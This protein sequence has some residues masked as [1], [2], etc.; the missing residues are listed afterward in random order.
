MTTKDGLVALDGATPEV[1]TDR[2]VQ[3][4]KVLDEAVRLRDVVS[5]AYLELGKVLYRIN[6]EGLYLQ[7]FQRYQTFN[8]YVEQELDFKISK[9][10]QL[11]STYWWFAEKVG[12]PELLAGL[13]EIGWTKAAML[14]G[15]ADKKSG[16]EWI[17]K[18]KVVSQDTLNTITKEALT[19]LGKTRRPRIDDVKPSGVDFTSSDGTA[20]SE[21][22]RSDNPF[23]E[24]AATGVQARAPEPEDGSPSTAPEEPVGAPPPTD[25]QVAEAEKF[26]V[27]SVPLARD[28]QSRNVEHA[29]EVAGKMA[30]SNKKSHLLDLIATHFLAASGA[31]AGDNWPQHRENFRWDLLQA[32]ERAFGLDIV[33]VKKGTREVVFGE[34]HLARFEDEG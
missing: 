27:F 20:P 7:G 3:A 15:V 23:E 16:A 25:E 2:Q 26:K 31:S 24:P 21:G 5:S 13:S 12:K 30:D 32:V 33:A 22:A 29:I 34:S 8:E 4:Q 9:A 28:T 19:Q 1:M 18:A 17:E 14:V 6:R 11:M 10:K